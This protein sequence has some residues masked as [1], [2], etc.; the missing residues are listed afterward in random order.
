MLEG[1]NGTNSEPLTLIEN[2]N[3]KDNAQ[4]SRLI[5]DLDFDES[6]IRPTLP[7]LISSNLNGINLE[8]ELQNKYSEDSFFHTILKN[9]KDFR[10]FECK[11][12]LIY[13]KENDH[14]L[15]CIPKILI[16]R[17]SA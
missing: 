14:T 7:E 9:P 6:I 15:L 11:D 17:R 3:D 4:P 10:N 12:G 16:E 8:K 13:L 5:P 1:E 2:L